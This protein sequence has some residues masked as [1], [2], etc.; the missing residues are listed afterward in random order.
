MMKIFIKY[1]ILS[2]L[3]FAQFLYAQTNNKVR[4]DIFSN[5]QSCWTIF[6]GTD[7]IIKNTSE[8]KNID[9]EITLY[10]CNESMDLMNS[11]LSEYNLKVNTILDPLCL[12][13]KHYDFSYLPAILIRDT[14]DSVVFKENWRGYTKYIQ[15][16]KKYI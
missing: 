1:A 8:L 9:L 5:E 4:V 16:I 11:L 13:P 10:F 12:Y 14:K 15:L 3:L 7:A 6:K 2:T